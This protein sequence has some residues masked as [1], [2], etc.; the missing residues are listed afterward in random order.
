MKNNIIKIQMYVPVM[1]GGLSYMVSQI[2]YK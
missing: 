2:V 1:I